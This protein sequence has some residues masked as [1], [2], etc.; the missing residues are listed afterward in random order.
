M[1]IAYRVL[2]WSLALAC[3]SAVSADTAP[4]TVYLTGP[5][6]L[7]QLR[8]TNPSHYAQAE[9]I[10]ASANQLCRPGPG[11]IE[12][13]TWQ[14][15]PKFTVRDLSCTTQILKTSNPPKFDVSFRLDSTLYIATVT[16]TDDPPRPLPVIRK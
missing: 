6:D 3:S 14:F 12:Y 4:S 1:R 16:V 15:A 8:R 5:S 11:Q 2:A 10:L 9:R 13:A 7:A